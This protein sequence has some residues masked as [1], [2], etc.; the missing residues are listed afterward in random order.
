MDG[1]D[2]TSIRRDDTV[3][4]GK[5]D[6]STSL[7]LKLLSSWLT[8]S[9]SFRWR[10]AAHFDEQSAVSE[11]PSLNIQSNGLDAISRT[12]FLPEI[13][14]EKTDIINSLAKTYG[15]RKY[16][17]I[18]TP[19][20]GLF[21]SKIDRGN[22]ETCHRLM[23][24][25]PKNFDDGLPIDFR[26]QID[27]SSELL[28][29]INKFIK[30]E[31][32][33]DLI[34]VDP[35]H[36]YDCGAIDMFGAFNLLAP[37][38]VMVIHDCSPPDAGIVSS[39]FQEGAWCGVT[40]QVYLEFAWSSDI[41]GYCTVDSDY[42]CGVVFNKNARIPKNIN[43]STPSHKLKYDWFKNRSD[44]DFRYKYFDSCRSSLLNLIAPD[45]FKEALNAS[46]PGAFSGPAEVV[47]VDILSVIP[48]VADAVPAAAEPPGTAI[49]SEPVPDAAPVAVE[50]PDAT[51]A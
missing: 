11:S 43:L 9:Y 29:V 17:E 7:P 31:D 27:N 47:A 25:C 35:Y 34:F 30:K 36:N 14:M 10:P 32:Y 13:D 21:Y 12:R 51:R 5:L 6:T 49:A 44:N 45:T 1:P 42:G 39:E 26:T 22:L 48:A 15:L 41:A 20:T 18:C 38:G 28:D 19:T 50:P 16:L 8:A 4:H 46:V 37:H 3:R 2:E 23:Y 24:R 33:Y 40:Y